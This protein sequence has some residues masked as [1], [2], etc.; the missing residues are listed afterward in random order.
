MGGDLQIGFPKAS[1]WVP[2]LVFGGGAIRSTPADAALVAVTSPMARLGAGV[3]R[4]GGPLVWFAELSAVGSK[5]E[6]FGFDR[7]QLD[8]QVRVGLAFGV[9]F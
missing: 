8:L 5:F 9:P 2:Y 6:G 7:L 4:I 1:S 3:N